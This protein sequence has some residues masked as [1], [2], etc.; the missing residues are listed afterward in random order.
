MERSENQLTLRWNT[1]AIIWLIF[2]H[3]CGIVFLFT[4]LYKDWAL[5]FS[6]LNLLLAFVVLI[7]RTSSQEVPF[8]KLVLLVLLI[9]LLGFFIEAI[10]VATG[11]P[12]GAYQYETRL[13]P[14]C[15]AVPPVIGLNW[16]GLVLSFV[17]IFEEGSK[18]YGL[19]LNRWLRAAYVGFAMMAFDF[20]LEPV[21]IQLDYWQWENNRIPTQNY[22]SWALLSSIF[23]FILPIGIENKVAKVYVAVQIVFFLLV[24]F[25]A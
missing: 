23:S 1:I 19:S 25:V 4:P 11:F 17:V 3:L 18:R 8:S 9:G 5:S 15:L 12:F 20:L 2:S 24:K 6:G 21:A 7:I 16:A 10:G 14:Q 13:G 22:A